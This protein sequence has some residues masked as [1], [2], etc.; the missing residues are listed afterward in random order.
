M[1]LKKLFNPKSIAIIGASNEKRSVGKALMDNIMPLKDKVLIYPVN[2]KRKNI[3]GLKAYKS[4]LD[5]DKKVD[6]AV[7]A[8][9]ASIVPVIMQEIAQAGIKN[10]VIISAGF[11]EVGKEG[12]VLLEKVKKIAIENNIRIMGPNC[13]GFMV[14]CLNLNVSFASRSA[15]CGNVALI[16]QS[17]ALC[18]SLLDWSEKNDIGFSKFISIGSMIDINFSD[19]IEFLENDSSTKAIVLYMESLSNKDKFMEV[20]KRVGQKKPIF[21]LK[22]GRSKAGASAAK[23]HTGSLAGNAEAFDALFKQCGVTSLDSIEDLFNS[24]IIHASQKEIG[25]K[26]AVITNAGGPGVITTDLLAA[27][28]VSLVTLKKEIINK[29]NQVLP[30]TWSHA[31]PIDVIGD[32]DPERIK[33]AIDVCLAEK[34]IESILL[35]ITPQAMT[36]AKKIAEDIVATKISKNK[37]IFVS[38]I[39]GTDLEEAKKIL[40]KAKI[41][42]FDTPREAVDSFILATNDISL[43]KKKDIRV[44]LKKKKIQ[45]I[46]D[47]VRADKRKNL[48]ELEAKELLSAAGLGLVNSSIARSAKEAGVIASKTREKLAMKILSPDILHKTDVGGVVLNIAGKNEAIGAYNKIIRSVRAKKKKAKIDGVIIEPM[49]KKGIELILGFSLDPVIGPV[50]MLGR[51]GV[52]VE[53]YKDVTFLVP[54]FEYGD[55]E[56]AIGIT[57]AYKL[58]KGYRGIE[59]ADIEKLIQIIYSLEILVKEFHEIKELDI[60]PLVAKG[61]EFLIIDAKVVLE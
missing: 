59:G 54:P 16:S 49:S 30:A 27:K 23:S 40:R 46:I 34:S 5:I 35:L 1:S 32:A 28:G 20:V 41:P 37:F 8:I 56:R 36:N 57:K 4:V 53:L 13:L 61:R 6:L 3:S 48:N 31:N 38:L 25:K 21:V 42:V 51:G 15:G 2:I 43:A 44:R 7:V 17:G 18:T 33:K 10:V 55:V 58:L 26:L 12:E 39:G 11:S 22:S 47:K 19:L 24:L 14:P 9:R 60:N 50:I 52:E 45:E 29:F